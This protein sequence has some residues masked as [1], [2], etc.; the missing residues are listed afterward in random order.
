MNFKECTF[1]FFLTEKNLGLQRNLCVEPTAC[2]KRRGSGESIFKI[3]GKLRIFI[4]K[5]LGRSMRCSGIEAIN[6]LL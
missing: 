4:A 5:P 1:E 3:L 6:I 2:L